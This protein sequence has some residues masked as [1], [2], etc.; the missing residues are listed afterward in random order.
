MKNNSSLAYN[1]CLIIGDALALLAAFVAAYILR[2]T[3]SHTPTSAQVY[4]HTYLA[5]FITL[6]PFFLVIFALLG[7]YNDK[8][9]ENRFSEFGRLLVGSFIS[10]LFV[11]S[12]SYIANV[13]VFPA[14]LVTLYGFLL[15]FLF[16][17]LFR[18]IARGVRKEFFSYGMGINNALI[19]GDTRLTRE[20]LDSL[21]D[22]KITGYRVVGVVGGVKH[23]LKSQTVGHL[24]YPSFE[25]AIGHMKVS[26]LHAIIQTELYA[27]QNKNDEILNYAQQHHIDY[28]FVPGN[29]ELF[30]GKID[31]ELFHSIP[32][33]AVHQT[34]LI[35]W[36]RVVKRLFD[37]VISVIGLILA[38]P[39][40]LLVAVTMKL[41]DRGPIFFKQAR[42]TRYN[43][44]FQVYKFR[45]VKTKYNGLTPEEAFTKMGKP[46]LIEAY[47]AN[48]DYLPNDPRFTPFSR[49]MRRLK[50]DEL[51]QLI[52][53]LHG[54]ISLVGPRAL[55]PQELNVYKKR[56]T[57]LAVKSGLTGLAQISGRSDISFEERRTLDIFYVQN[58]SFWGD[59]VILIKT[60]SVVLFQRGTR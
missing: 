27:D 55:V 6:L 21:A 58:W 30:V 1:I 16:V 41:F 53:V 13:Q 52:N 25:D 2:V 33:I 42:L 46:E 3:I 60:I 36:G 20:L 29:S 38:S 9:Y 48:A 11:I 57:I 51:P 12:Y 47:R 19:V 23:P 4:A 26:K 59:I 44:E 24:L 54:D 15:A 10:V 40:F 56:H 28:R 14:R 18:T 5:V 45:T 37:I 8:N 22:T 31:V 32:M 34:A 39:I 43:Q 49:F 50:L 7:L 35:G 17:L